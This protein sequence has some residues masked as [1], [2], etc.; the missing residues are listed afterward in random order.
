MPRK[1]SGEIKTSIIKKK[2]KNGDL[3]A[4]E[5]K[6]RYDS[7]KGN[8]I[9][10]G[11]KILGK[12]I[13]GKII[14]TRSKKKN[15][16]ENSI[17]ENKESLELTATKNKVGANNI[18]DYIGKK[19]QIDQN[20]YDIADIGDARKII[21]IARYLVSTGGH[22]LPAIEEWQL[23]HKLPYED[24]ITQKVYGELFEKIGFNTNL[25]QNY[26]KKRVN[27]CNTEL[28]IAYDSSTLSTYSTNQEYARYGY[29][30][31]GLNLPTIKYIILYSIKD[32]QPIAFS[33]VPG[34]LPDVT[35]VINAIKQLQALGIKV[36]E[37]ATDNGY[38]SE[39]NIGELLFQKMNFITL[40]KPSLKWVKDEIDKHIDEFSNQGNY[41]TSEQNMI[42]F[43]V[44][45]TRQFSHV[46]QKSDKRTGVKKGDKQNFNAKIYLHLY[47][48]ED[49]KLEEDRKNRKEINEIMEMINNGLNP[50]DLDEKSYKISQK[51]LKIT[52]KRGGK[53]V[54]EIDSDA[55]KEV[56]KYNGMMALIS[57]KKK[58]SKSC[59][60]KYRLREKIE[61]NFGRFK[62]DCD[63]NRVR[64]WSDI[65]F[66]GRIFVQF[67]AL[68]Y[69]DC[70]YSELKRIKKEIDDVIS[71]EKVSK[72]E[73]S[74]YR[75]LKTWLHDMSLERILMWFD[76]IE[77]TVVSSKLSRKYWTTETTKR[78]EL[79]LNLLV[80]NRIN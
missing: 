42:G 34:N 52:K 44:P 23:N 3:Y 27:Y 10:L 2:Q 4:Y 9:C 78:D 75:S 12:M 53:Y 74:V 61:E 1:A 80:V 21:S 47:L 58:N 66:Q 49:K 77:E 39:A 29:N 33:R 36:A 68:G 14:E 69:Y 63:G 20:L 64:V 72:Q 55:V 6:Y 67:V 51:C 40:V 71:N 38:Y 28:I 79:F 8:N 60:K 59:L 15:N 41:C 18:L 56:N 17:D 46:I 22:T 5:R 25:V 35:S 50:E 73:L 30:K 7:E 48:N 26:F 19:S 62:D 31:E 45:V 65:K 13:D 11:D 24:G 16:L 70:F 57:N 54:A 32:E 43:V 37:M 76:T